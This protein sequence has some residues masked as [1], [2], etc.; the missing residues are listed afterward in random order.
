[1]Q[2]PK[3]KQYRD[4]KYLAFVRKRPCVSCFSQ[5][6]QRDAHH[7][8]QTFY[9]K[10]TALKPHDTQAVALCADGEMCHRLDGERKKD[11]LEI[12]RWKQEMIQ[13]LS[14]WIDKEHNVDPQVLIVNLLTGYLQSQK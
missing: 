13:S 8:D 3:I 14:E 10:G 2:I 1:M 12:Y 9:N 7:E 4:K 11:E 5:C 6:N